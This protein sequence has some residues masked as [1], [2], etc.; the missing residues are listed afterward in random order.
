M[1]Y[2]SIQKL[3]LV[4]ETNLL[5]LGAC[6]RIHTGLS[7]AVGSVDIIDIPHQ[8]ESLLLADVFIESAAEVVGDIVFP[9]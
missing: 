5:E 9:V 2:R 1:A 7:P 8:V 3:Q 4:L 6:R